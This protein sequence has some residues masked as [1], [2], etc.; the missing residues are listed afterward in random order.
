[1]WRMILL[2]YKVPDDKIKVLK[3]LKQLAKKI[4]WKYNTSDEGPRGR[5]HKL[6][7]RKYWD[8]T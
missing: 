1:M 3:E 7:S 6:A 5:K 4:W 2:R 8:D